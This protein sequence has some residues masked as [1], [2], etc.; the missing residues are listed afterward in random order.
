MRPSG[1]APDQMRAIT[2]EPGFT[3][4]AEGSCLVSFGDTRVLCTAS[5]EDQRPAV[6]ARQGPGLGH[7][8]IWHAA[9]RHPHPRQPRGGQG[10]AIGPDPGNPAADRPLAARGGRSRRRSASA[11]S[12]SIATSS[13]PTAAPAPPRFPAPG[14]RCGSRSTSCSQQEADRRRPDPPARSRRSAA[15]STTAPPVL[16]LDYDEDSKA[17][18]DGNFVLTADGKIVEAQVTAEGECFDEEGLLR[19][20]RLARIGCARDF[21]GAGQGDRP[22]R[23]LGP[24]S[25]SSPATIRARCARSP[26]CSRR[27]GIEPVVARPSSTCPSPTR[28]APASPTMPT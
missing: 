15:A 23:K 10:Q 26:S 19:L 7:R 9:P 4:H 24:A 21:R 5:V 2:I 25:W 27:Y 1:R 22:V 16:D 28:P 20:L 17:G 11:R 14:W 6:A 18:C 12:R 3:R 13:R 8:R